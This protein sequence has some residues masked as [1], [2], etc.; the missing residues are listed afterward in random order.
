MQTASDLRALNKNLPAVLEDSATGF[1]GRAVLFSGGPS[2]KSRR[3]EFPDQFFHRLCLPARIRQFWRDHSPRKRGGK[4][5]AAS[6]PLERTKRLFPPDGQIRTE[7]GEP[8]DLADRRSMAEKGDPH[9][10]YDLGRMYLEGQW[11]L[12]D[13]DRGIELIR[14]AAGKGFRHAVGFLATRCP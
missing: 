3:C 8:A 12:Q 5:K 13:V 7:A 6:A 14:R 1:A 2:G 4:A 9:G 11:V 10:E